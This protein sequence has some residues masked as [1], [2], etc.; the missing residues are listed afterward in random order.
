MVLHNATLIRIAKLK[1]ESLND[2]IHVKGL[3]EAKI[4]KFGNGILDIIEKY[5][6]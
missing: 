3:G 5:G 6:R 1:P 4:S 2:L